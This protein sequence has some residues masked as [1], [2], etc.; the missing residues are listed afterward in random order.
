MAGLRGNHSFDEGRSMIAQTARDLTHTTGLSVPIWT[1]ERRFMVAPLLHSCS[2]P[3]HASHSGTQ[4]NRPP[5]QPSAGTPMPTSRPI[6][7]RSKPWPKSWKGGM[8]CTRATSRSSF[9]HSTA[10]SAM[11]AAAGPGPASQRPSSAA[12]RSAKSRGRSFVRSYP[13][14]RRAVVRAAGFRS[15]KAGC[16]T[17]LCFVA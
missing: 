13:R 3:L 2:Q 8:A 7:A 1:G 17:L 5:R 9:R 11:L 15:S 14:H 4:C 16:K 10:W 6:H 12:R